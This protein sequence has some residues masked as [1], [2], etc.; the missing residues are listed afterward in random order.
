[1]KSWKAMQKQVHNSASG[2][3]IIYFQHMYDQYIILND[4]NNSAAR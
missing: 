4:I 2:S 1:M 3:S